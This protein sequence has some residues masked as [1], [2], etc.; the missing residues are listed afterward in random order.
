MVVMMMMITLNALDYE[1]NYVKLV[2][3][4]NDRT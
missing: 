1:A 4:L 2:N 3:K